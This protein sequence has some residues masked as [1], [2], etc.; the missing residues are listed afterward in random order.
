[1][2]WNVLG[3][4]VE[5]RG[6][7][8]YVLK[9]TRVIC[10]PCFYGDHAGCR[11]YGQG[12]RFETRERKQ[13]KY[14]ECGCAKQ[15]HPIGDTCCANVSSHDGWG[16]GRRCSRPAK[17]E[18]PVYWVGTVTKGITVPGCGTH[19]AAHKRSTANAE[20]RAAESAAREAKRQREKE[21][22][23][24]ATEMLEMHEEMLEDLGMPGLQTD[25]KGNITIPVENLIGLLRRLP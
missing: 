14:P 19:L 21:A 18:I 3:E 12:D 9:A 5:N 16:D 13:E 23:R 1:M 15:G 22:D 17:G 10:Q 6:R 11:G 8:H 24:A 4:G 25:G 20:A 2:A 7:G